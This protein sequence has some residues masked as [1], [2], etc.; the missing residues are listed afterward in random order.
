MIMNLISVLFAVCLAADGS[1]GSPAIPASKLAWVDPARC[2]PVCAFDPGPALL[3]VNDAAKPDPRGKHRAD[4]VAAP[5]LAEL[6]AAAR[7]A[8]H[9]LRVKS[10]FRSYGDQ[11]FVFGK[12]KEAGRAARPGHSEHQLGTAFDLTLPNDAAGAWLAEHA[13]LYGFTVSYPAKKQRLTGYRPEPWH[14]RFVGPPLGSELHRRGLT[15]EEWFREHPETGETGNCGDC[16]L[17]SSRAP[18]GRVTA[19]GNCRG[20]VMTWCYDGALAAVDCALSNE[21]C[22]RTPNGNATC[23]GR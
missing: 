16:P 10:A 19:E 2:L 18:C 4:A 11:A 1:S 8:G 12:T 21:S 15:L 20:N 17:P 5:A 13:H 3:R 23:I 14:V 9:A 22:G 6:V 7:K